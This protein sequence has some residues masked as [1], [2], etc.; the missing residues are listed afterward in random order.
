MEKNTT[1]EPAGASL[2]SF[3]PTVENLLTGAI[4]DR[5]MLPWLNGLV[6]SQAFLERFYQVPAVE[7]VPRG[8]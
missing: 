3:L 4:T 6:L 5:V 7:S 1:T 2:E 8:G